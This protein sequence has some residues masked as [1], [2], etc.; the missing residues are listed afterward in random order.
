M[1]VGL[2]S[3]GQ[4]LYTTVALSST[5]S[6]PIVGEVPVQSAAVTFG[7]NDYLTTGA[8]VHGQS[9]DGGGLGEF[10]CEGWFKVRIA[11]PPTIDLMRGPPGGGVGAVQWRMQLTSTGAVQSIMR[12]GAAGATTQTATS[13]AGIIG[14]NTWYHIA[15]T[16]TASLLRVYVNGVQVA[17]TSVSGDMPLI[18][19]GGEMRIGDSG[20]VGTGT[21]MDVGR[22][23]FYRAGLDGARVV[24]HYQAGQ[25]RGFDAQLPGAR[26]SSVLDAASVTTNRTL[27]TGT[28]SVT[29]SYMQGQNPLDEI[30]TARNADAVDAMFFASR[31]GVL[32]FLADGHRSS[33]P[34]NTVQATFD[35]DGTDLPYVDIGLDYSESFLVNEWNSTRTGQEAETQTV[36]DATSIARYRKR[37]QSLNPPVL[38][39]GD[40]LTIASAMLAKYKDPMTRVTSITL[41]TDVPDVA[42]AIFRRDLGDRIR[43]FRTPPGGG[44]RIDQTLFIQKIDVTAANDG[45]PWTVTWGLSPL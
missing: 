45:R 11:L 22:V 16:V 35:D 17:S 6:S 37:S 28:R 21:E 43:V 18:D 23:A 38:T 32:V 8:L 7:D 31:S 2:V 1:G 44:A 24:A 29:P 10:T 13:V 41:T 19:A 3:I 26:I 14:L 25:Q 15:A 33:S 9:G 42:E 39:D 4:D 27:G 30:R 34:Y 12:T 36:R 5:A 40:A 20:M